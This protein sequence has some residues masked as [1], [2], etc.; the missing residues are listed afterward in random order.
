[1]LEPA[2]E[3]GDLVISEDSSVI[4]N[5]PNKD[6]D[7]LIGSQSYR[8]AG[9]HK[10]SKQAIKHPGGT[11]VG[12]PEEQRE[13]RKESCGRSKRLC[14]A[15]RRPLQA[16]TKS[17]MSFEEARKGEMENIDQL[18]AGQSGRL[19][20]LRPQQSAKTPNRGTPVEP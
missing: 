11:F 14:G 8:F 12:T 16:P 3:I 17:G 5:I 18:Q 6:E 9:A 7:V 2:D 13:E 1:M 20:D 4:G 19:L 10:R 15:I